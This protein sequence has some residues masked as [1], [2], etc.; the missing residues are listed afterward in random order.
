MQ[1]T[2]S[3]KDVAKTLGIKHYRIHYAISTGSI[4][5]PK[6]R[7]NN[8]RVFQKDDLRRVAAHFGV[9]LKDEAGAE[10]L[11]KAGV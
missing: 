11:A 7:F 10:K 1:E 8:R 9:E 6:L 2:W 4:E 5:E 3:L